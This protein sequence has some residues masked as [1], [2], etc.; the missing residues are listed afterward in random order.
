MNQLC[1]VLKFIFI[2]CLSSN[3]AIPLHYER[4]TDWF[5]SG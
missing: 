5:G 2:I 3:K 4:E 1:L